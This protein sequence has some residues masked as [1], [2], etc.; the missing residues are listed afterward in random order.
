MI[1]RRINRKGFFFSHIPVLLFGFIMFDAGNI[2]GTEDP[3]TDM[4]L[5]TMAVVIFISLYFFI[6]LWRVNDTKTRKPMFR[7]V[8]VTCMVFVLLTIIYF[9]MHI[10]PNGI[11][12]SASILIAILAFSSIIELT[13]IQFEKTEK[14]PKPRPRITK[15][16]GL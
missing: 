9:N 15:S 6:L 16:L 1:H 4:V 3:A 7:A 10:S 2:V 8:V 5:K 12:N 11:E 14:K 13:R